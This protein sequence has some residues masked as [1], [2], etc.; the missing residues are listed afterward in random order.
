MEIGVFLIF[1]VY[2]HGGVSQ[3]RV[4]VV[5]D[6]HSI[7]ARRLSDLSSRAGER[8]MAETKS[9]GEYSASPEHDSGQSDSDPNFEETD[10][11]EDESN[12]E[13]VLDMLKSLKYCLQ[14]E[15]HNPK[16]ASSK[17]SRSILQ[18]DN[19]I[20]PEN[21]LSNKPSP[22]DDC[23]SPE[24]FELDGSEDIVVDI[25]N[26]HDAAIPTRTTNNSL[27][28]FILVDYEDP[29]EEVKSPDSQS[30]PEIG[31]QKKT[32]GMYYLL[33]AVLGEQW[34]AMGDEGNLKA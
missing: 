8:K 20:I 9:D 26:S 5:A 4:R 23:V 15:T 22:D 29:M 11:S 13:A 16:P 2:A 28:D 32:H 17:Q 14:M 21:P 25:T 19:C 1:S 18:D 24:P 10:E 30:S 31:Y 3:F 12:N 7:I 6:M 27:M 34:G 33:F